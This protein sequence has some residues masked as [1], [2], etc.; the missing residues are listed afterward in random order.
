M[1]LVRHVAALCSLRETLWGLRDVLP[2]FHPKQKLSFLLP[3]VETSLQK[4]HKQ[5]LWA[6]ALI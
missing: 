2:G 5:G 4:E 3:A 1:S 6:Q